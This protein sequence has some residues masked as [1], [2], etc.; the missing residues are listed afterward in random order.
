LAQ[1]QGRLPVSLTIHRRRAFGERLQGELQFTSIIG[2]HF[3]T[4][5]YKEGIAGRMEVQDE[6]FLHH[7]VNEE[8][9]ASQAPLQKKSAKAT[10]SVPQ[11]K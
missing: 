7:E 1:L 6:S 10:E 9:I 5:S 8:S 11:T 4:A 2:R 3:A